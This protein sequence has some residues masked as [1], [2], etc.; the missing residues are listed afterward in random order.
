LSAPEPSV[1][2]TGRESLP[3]VS[4]QNAVLEA[5]PN[6]IVGVDAK[7]AIVYVNPQVRTTFGY[8]RDE[9]VGQP[10]E[11]LLPERVGERHVAHRDAFF[12]H[13]VAR[14][15]GIGMDLAGRRKDGTE[16]PAE[17]S[18]SPVET[19]NGRLVFATVVDITARKKSEAA[20]AESERRF[21]AV[22]EASPNA[23]VAVD[24]RAR[25]VYVNPQVEET[26][27][28]RRD[29][30]LGEPIEF[31]L[32]D[33][34]K[35][36]H[37]GHRDGFFLNP[38]VRPMGIG[39]DLAGRRKDGS[40]VPVEISLSP[41]QTDEGIQVFATVVDITARKAA[42][43]QLLQAQKL[44]SIGRL[45]GGIAHDFNNMLFAI[46]GYA[47]LLADDLTA[48]NLERLD[49]ERTLRNLTQI[50]GAAERATALTSQLLAFS[51]Q[52]IVSVR[53]L[54]LGSAVT[55]IEPMLRPLIGEN[56][57][58][59]L[60][61]DPAAGHIRADSGQVDQI[62]VN[63]V[64]NARDAMANGGTVTIET[65]NVTFE[66]PYAL[67]H[68]DVAPGPYVLLAVSDT[69]AGM[70]RETREHVFEPFF[71]TK[72]V[73]KGTGLG[74]ATIYGIVRQAGGHI[75]LY[76]EPGHGST[77][78]LYFPRVDDAVDV[79]STEPVSTVVGEGTVLVVEDEPM[80]REMTTQLLERAGYLVLP[81]ADAA[82]ALS[83][84]S[85]VQPI[86]VLVTDVIM[87]NMSGIELAELLMDRYP[88]LSVVL[89]SGYTAETLDLERVTARGATFVPKPLTSNQLL[90]AVQQAAGSARARGE[91]R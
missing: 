62:L 40:E 18:L 17:I 73:G 91:R 27:G 44:E 86:D 64:V 13:P 74:L 78:K 23:V 21:R 1:A 9:V 63:L 81:V 65:G 79:R 89:L 80:V 72:E 90:A 75:W 30:I 43:S 20:L 37:V 35:E 69:G 8:D 47:E 4:A 68:F 29:E 71:T 53:V 61:L 77:F 85:I 51:R 2:A 82:E 3:N 16:F 59:N 22:L 67:E 50:S 36:R 10:I 26:F 57:R 46:R 41:V 76:S 11:L 19:A 66:E 49:T 88:H 6:A 31:L 60:N 5:S 12:G 55:A 39:L 38:A 70:D 58:L 33:R 24:A 25:I 14:P 42:E 83:S 34:V 28:Y 32:P 7:G 48:E 87:P 54:E 56:I 15:M 52:Q 84:T 45:A